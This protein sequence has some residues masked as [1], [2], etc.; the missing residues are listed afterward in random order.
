MALPLKLPIP[1]VFAEDQYSTICSKY[2]YVCASYYVGQ[3]IA[4][5]CKNLMEEFRGKLGC[6]SKFVCSLQ[7]DNNPIMQKKIMAIDKIHDSE[8]L[9]H[10][11]SLFGAI[12]I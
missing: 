2:V 1:S 4:T 8:S 9:L 3:G 5:E 12:C 10:S 7:L 11:N 6:C